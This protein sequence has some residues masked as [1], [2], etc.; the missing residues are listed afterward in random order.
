VGHAAA[1][2]EADHA[3]WIAEALTDHFLS[4]GRFHE[5][6]T[7]LEIALT[8]ADRATDR[9]M[10]LSLR[11]G[12]GLTLMHRA[13]F[14]E[15]LTCLKQALA[16]SREREDGREEAR[17]LVGLGT[18]AGLGTAGPSTDRGRQGASWL[19]SGL[20]LAQQCDDQWLAAMAS[21]ALGL[22]HHAQGRND[23]ALACFRAAFVPSLIIGHPRAVN[24][25]LTSNF[26]LYLYLDRPGTQTLLRQVAGLVQETGD[27]PLH[28]LTLTRLGTAE[29]SAG[30]LSA[31]AA[32]YQQALAQHRTLAPRDDPDHDRNEMDIRC[33]LGRSY[34]AAGQITAARDQF[35]TALAIPGA[36]RHPKEHAQAVEGLSRSETLEQ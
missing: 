23:E 13:R 15:A 18:M 27:V 34:Y 3:C 28:T 25:A 12:L 5:C 35:S 7:A 2:G 1:F 17:A 11:N 6:Q 33:R 26:D 24:R 8:Q 36:A 9:R 32:A 19:A 30:N 10:D 29:H 14:P 4:R 21:F 20:E 22:V 16:L 31:A